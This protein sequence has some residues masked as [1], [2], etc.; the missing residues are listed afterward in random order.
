M[1]AA[2]QRSLDVRRRGSGPDGTLPGM[3]PL[4]SDAD[5]LQRAYSEEGSPDWVA[6]FRWVHVS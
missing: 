4:R 1:D 6:E 3:R 5:G 2:R